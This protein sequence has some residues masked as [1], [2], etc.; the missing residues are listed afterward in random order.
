MRFHNQTRWRG[1]NKP[2]GKP[3]R[4]VGR[5][6]HQ[7]QST[8]EICF[9]ARVKIIWSFNE[10]TCFFVFFFM[11]IKAK[12]FLRESLTTWPWT[13]TVNKKIKET[14]WCHSISRRQELFKSFKK[15][16]WFQ[17]A[18]CETDKKQ[19]NLIKAAQRHHCGSEL[20]CMNFDFVGLQ[21]LKKKKGQLKIWEF[22]HKPWHVLP[23]SF[24]FCPS[25]H[26]Q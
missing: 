11:F 23:S 18:L 20:L 8:D 6:S 26:L 10:V 13:N 17:L 15:M 25:G 21:G 24:S 1:Y 9:S 19:F 5:D 16:R 3:T 14:Q 22:K 4:K 2:H 12:I 7:S